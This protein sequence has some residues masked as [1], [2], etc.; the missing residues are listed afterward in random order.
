MNQPRRFKASLS[1]QHACTHPTPHQQQQDA[2]ERPPLGD[3]VSRLR[4]LQES[5]ALHRCAIR[6]PAA[7]VAVAAAGCCGADVS[8]GVH[9]HPVGAAPVPPSP[10]MG[11]RGGQHAQHAQQ[12]Q[13]QQQARTAAAAAAA[14]LV[15]TACTACAV[16][17]AAAAAAGA[18]GVHGSAVQQQ[19]GAGGCSTAAAVDCMQQ[20]QQQY[21]RTQV[22]R[23]TAVPPPLPKSTLA[24][25]NLKN[26][27]AVKAST[28]TT[29]LWLYSLL[30]SPPTLC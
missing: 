24:F 15:P 6:K 18:A 19:Q 8:R 4:L 25:L 2:A 28:A 10:L 13:Q 11:Q 5:G 16:F 17:T 20:H 12:Q 3:V 29:P 30:H 22:A 21:S 1:K 27:T 7:A 14:V 9:Q 26:T 23:P